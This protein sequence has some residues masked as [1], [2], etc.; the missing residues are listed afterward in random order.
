[1]K[2]D[3]IRIHHEDYL[4]DIPFWKTWAAGSDPI[5]EVGCGHGRVT[6]PLLE[7]GRTVVGV[8]LDQDAILYLSGI[9][10][11]L[12]RGLQDRAVIIQ[13]DILNFLP[14]QTFGAII[15]PCNTYSTFS[16][17]ERTQM[18]VNFTQL[19]EPGGLLVVSTPNPIEIK[20]IHQSLWGE[21][22]E[23]DT[24]L[25]TTFLHP[26]TN[27]PVQVSSRLTAQLDRVQWTWIY[28]HLFPD[29]NVSRINKTT[30][31]YLASLEIYIQEL[32]T[33][34]FSEI[35]NQGDF[36]GG[37][38]DENAPYLIISAKK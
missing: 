21:E 37:E 25:E 32:L 33:A 3:L 1:M 11:G 5:L 22:S 34:G 36:S 35:T 29:G 18:L 8:D 26:E 23:N 2:E 10:Q 12:S 15:I 30:E 38:Y 20:N 4:E 31:H 19:L 7:S 17:D 9:L 27:Y 14:D 24:D 28:D 6:I 16:A 13:E